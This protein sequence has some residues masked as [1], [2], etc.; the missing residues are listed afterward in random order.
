MHDH[1]PTHARPRVVLLRTVTIIAMLISQ[2]SFAPGVYAQDAPGESS[3]G[4]FLPI[5]ANNGAAGAGE[6]TPAEEPAPVEEAE[7][8]AESGQVSASAAGVLVPTLDDFVGR[9]VF[10]IIG[11]RLVHLVQ[12]DILETSKHEPFFD[13]VIY[14]VWHLMISSPQLTLP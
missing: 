13:F 14:L 2:F 10:S 5:V 1:Q 12:L 4:I 6:Q 11:E 7:V 9:L 3:N 8:P